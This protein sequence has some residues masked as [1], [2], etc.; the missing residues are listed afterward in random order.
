MPESS[1]S[2][3]TF[4]TLKPPVMNPDLPQS[5]K[6]ISRKEFV[7][8]A[9]ALGAFCCGATAL[10]GQDG[11]AP[12]T[13][14]EMLKNQ[15]A[16]MRKRMARLVLAL[17]ES[18]REKVLETMGRECAREFSFLTEKYKGNV[19]G[20]LEDAKRQWIARA[21]Y[22]KE[23]KTI[24]IADSGKSCTCAFVESGITPSEFCSCSLG[25]QKEAYSTIMGE[26]MDAE[27]KSSILKGDDHCGFR[28]RCKNPC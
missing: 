19:E 15:I 21:D 25:W 26:P 17:D 27:L 10:M 28:I 24:D 1:Y 18:T 11:T 20:F 2:L 5:T 22:N 9:T 12:D 14:V 6:T 4:L 8:V 7:S 3:L 13:E 23:A 16:F